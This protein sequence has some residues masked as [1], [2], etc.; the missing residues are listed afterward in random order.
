MRIDHLTLTNFKGF[1]S[2][3]IEL[4]S[5]FNLFVGDNATGKTSILDALTLA[6]DSWF[7]GVQVDQTSGR[8]QAKEVRVEPHDFDDSAFFEA[9]YP[10]RVDAHGI[11]M[12]EPVSWSRELKKPGGRTTSAEEQGLA[13]IAAE[14][15][16]KVR[17]GEGVEL[18][19]ICSYG[20]ERL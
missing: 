6:M 17:A 9:Q 5:G 13:N 14:A 8:I 19:L 1:A 20:A 15:D 7:L 11:V 3:E 12:D 18:P 4:N 10:A 16:R 2:T